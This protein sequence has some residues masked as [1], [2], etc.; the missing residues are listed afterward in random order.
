MRCRRASTPPSASTSP[1]RNVRI[2]GR[3]T[4]LL[5]TL[6]LLTL[7]GIPMQPPAAHAAEVIENTAAFTYTDGVGQPRSVSSN[8]AVVTVARVAGVSVAPVDGSGIGE[9]GE[10]IYYA[11]SVT[12]EGN[13]ADAFTL[14]AESASSPAWPVTIHLDDGAGGGIPNDGIQQPGE[15]TVAS[16]ASLPASGV[17]HCFVAVTVPIDET[18]G[19]IDGTVFTATSQFDAAVSAHAVFT[20]TVQTARLSGKVLDAASGAGLIANV[21]A[22]QGSSLVASTVAAAPDGSYQFGEDLPAGTYAVNAARYGYMPQTVN[23]VTVTEGATTTLDFSLAASAVLEGRVTDAASGLPLASA[24]IELYQDG[25]L[26][27]STSTA[28][29]GGYGIDSGLPDGTYSVTVSQFGYVPQTADIRITSGATTNL[30]FS[31]VVASPVLTGQVTDEAS[32]APVAGAAIGL[33]QNRTL[34]VSTT[35]AS[36]GSYRMGTGMPAGTCTVSVSKSGY[37]KSSQSLTLQPGVI[38][39]NFPLK[40]VRR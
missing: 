30:D 23:D 4:S 26:V 36:D 38:T 6:T 31:L 12:N 11:V 5:A 28:D 37:K 34:R 29:D 13:G 21:F 27:V 16:A 35:S 20:T 39:A 17:L 2:R 22:Y 24:T 7:A 18:A 19:T 25:V 3:L 33:Y 15:T 14:K 10:V 40:R 32:G 8:T 1:A 9:P